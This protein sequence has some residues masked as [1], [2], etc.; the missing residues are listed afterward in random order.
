MQAPVSYKLLKQQL[1]L[2]AHRCVFWEEEKALIVSDLHFGKTGHFRKSGIA[3]PQAVYKEDL[4]R[5]VHLLQYFQPRLLIVVGDLFHSHQNKELE[6][7]KRWRHDFPDL[8]VHLIKGNHDILH[9]SWYRQCNILVTEEELQLGCFRFRHDLDEAVPHNN[10]YFFSG[11]I[12]PGVRIKGAAKQSLSF[13]CFY[14]AKAF[15]VLPAF[16]RFTGIALVRPEYEE[17][18]FAIVNDQ[19]VQLQ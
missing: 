11:H 6:L 16:S 19:I 13:P 12:H 7:F 3:V 15:C 5:L 8:P 17:N 9:E 10:A 1:W 4:H 2:S 14:F 18:V